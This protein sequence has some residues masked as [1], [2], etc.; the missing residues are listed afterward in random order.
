[1]MIDDI[2]NEFSKSFSYVQKLDKF[3]LGNRQLEIKKTKC[4]KNIRR[5]KK[6]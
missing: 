6:N 5:E 4:F 3:W 2:K 1:M